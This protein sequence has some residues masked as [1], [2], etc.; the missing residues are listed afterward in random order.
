MGAAGLSKLVISLSSLARTGWMLRGVPSSLAE[1]VAEHLFSSS[2]IALEAGFRMKGRGYNIDPFKAASI[3]LV[4]DLAEAYIGDI[5]R[6]S[7]VDKSVAEAKAFSR[8][9]LSDGIKRLY[10]EYEDQNTLEALVA[11]ASEAAATYL[12]ACAFME[13]GYDVS[14]I[15]DSMRRMI[16]DYAGHE[17]LE[18]IIDIVNESVSSGCRINPDRPK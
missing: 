15:A 13:T 4:H 11:R 2:L 5:A 1:T 6:V 16:I 8:L 10:L 18:V 3:A 17:G 14:E 12:R 9:P 7:G